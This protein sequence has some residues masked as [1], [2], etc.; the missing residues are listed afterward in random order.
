MD[1]PE[2]VSHNFKDIIS[3]ILS[4]DPSK[5]YGIEDIEEH[6]WFTMTNKPVPT[7]GIKVGIHVI[8]ADPIVLGELK[9]IGFDVFHAKS[10]I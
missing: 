5:R 1:F 10:S 7:L 4:I 3:R 2:N 9:K 8:K 6:P